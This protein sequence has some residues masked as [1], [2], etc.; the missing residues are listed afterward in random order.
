MQLQFKVKDFRWPH[1]VWSPTGVTGLLGFSRCGLSTS[2]VSPFLGL[3]SFV[4]RLLDMAAQRSRR[5]NV[6][7]AGFKVTEPAQNQGQGH[8]TL[9]GSSD[10]DMLQSDKKGGK[11]GCSHLW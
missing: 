11:E 4:P 9:D 8:L 6:D 7:S 10:K 2:L 1:P 5:T 3:T